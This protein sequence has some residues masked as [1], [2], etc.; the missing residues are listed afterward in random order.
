[1]VAMIFSI[2]LRVEAPGNSGFP[3]NISANIQP[4]LH[5]S[6]PFVYLKCFTQSV[7]YINFAV[8]Y[9]LCTPSPVSE[10]Q[11]QHRY[12]VSDSLEHCEES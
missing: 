12:N 8:E 1:M 6:T 4:K 2:W 7:F 3:I 5:M 9:T 10:F 11:F